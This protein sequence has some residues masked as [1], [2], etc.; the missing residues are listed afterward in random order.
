MLLVL[1]L[2]GRTT[3]ADDPEFLAAKTTFEALDFST[4]AS[5]QRSLIWLA[6]YEG[7]PDGDFGRLTFEAIRSYQQS[8]GAKPDGVLDP[9]ALRTLTT[10]ALAKRLNVDFTST[11]D[12]ATGEIVA[13][14]H[15]I[16]SKLTSGR[17]QTVA[18][19]ADGS[20][21][22]RFFRQT[23]PSVSLKSV[24]AT[25]LKTSSNRHATYRVPRTGDPSDTFVVSGDVSGKSFYTRAFGRKDDV[26]GFTAIWDPKKDPMFNQMVVA[27][28]A[29]F[30]PFP[31]DTAIAAL[32]KPNVEH[33][34]EPTDRVPPVVTVVPKPVAAVPAAPPAVAIGTG[35]FIGREKRAIVPRAV[36]NCRNPLAEGIGGLTIIDRT[37]SGPFV[38]AQ[39]AQAPVVLSSFDTSKPS[40]SDS[41]YV[42]S[43][44]AAGAK[45][46][47]IGGGPRLSGVMLLA[48]AS[49]A[50][51]Q[52]ASA[53]PSG[54]QGA[55]VM[56]GRGRVI[57]I[58]ADA[59]SDSKDNPDWRPGPF[60]V[61]S[62]A[63]VLKDLKLEAPAANE[64]QN[65]MSF[66]D[67]AHAVFSVLCPQ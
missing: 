35:F 4:R 20:I 16:V 28:V 52:I 47:L 48:G 49:D 5:I 27:I 37:T 31:T 59:P 65:S 29:E 26:R 58:V 8:I 17:N 45:S 30:D 9:A 7:L 50:S 41:Y 61:R 33:T 40:F 53:L 6:S 15:R 39:T 57:G 64:A 10:A 42:L 60:N 25:E 1:S 36:L 54:A 12:A 18:S 24:F 43:D 46:T 3:A 55:P 66:D 63:A 21:Q 23:G 14:P 13:M 62:I 11:Y 22:I 44:V 32:R 38:T 19:S 34:P 67:M 2:A 51:Y 56:D